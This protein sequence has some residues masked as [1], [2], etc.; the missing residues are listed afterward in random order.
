MVQCG[1]DKKQTKSLDREILGEELAFGRD[2]AEYQLWNEAI[3]RW[4]KVLDEDPGNVNAINNLAVAYETVGNFDRA[5]DLYKTALELNE[6]SPRI[7]QNY[8]RFLSFY[9]K[10][11]RQLAREKRAREAQQAEARE[12]AENDEGGR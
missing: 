6:D 12:E 3:F 4:E 7:R 9:K 1:P 10:H 11:Q 8:K 2:A 5:A